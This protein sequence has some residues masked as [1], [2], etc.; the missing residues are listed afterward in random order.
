VND[1]GIL[2]GSITSLS[3]DVSGLNTAF[4][5]EREERRT[6]YSSLT[7]SLDVM[8]AQQQ[9]NTAL[10]SQEQ[11]ARA[12]GDEVLASSLSALQAVAGGHTATLNTLSSTAVDAFE[13]LVQLSNSLSAQNYVVTRS[14][15]DPATSGAPNEGDF[16][17]QVPEDD[18]A[19]GPSLLFRW[20]SGAWVPASTLFGAMAGIQAESLAR[21]T[22]TESLAESISSLSASTEEGFAGVTET[23]QALA[24]T[25]GELGALYTVSL[26]TT[27]D[28]DGNPQNLVGGFGLY[29]DNSTVQAG[30]DV[31]SFWVGRTGQNGVKPFIISDGVVYINEATIKQV[32]LDK[33]RTASGGVVLQDGKIKADLLDVNTATFSGTLNVKSAESGA[34]MEIKNNTIKVYDADG[35]VRVHIGDLSA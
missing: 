4:V 2:T 1:Q 7:Q 23:V 8:Y 31:D 14:S 5:S 27:T 33:L 28:G 34:R 18:A 3:L 35:N 30:F 9:E 25:T 11:I 20:E 6:A 19:T 22:A 32:T 13:T 12:E 24:D 26:T 21:T 15:D 10:I 17:V 16:W 29:N